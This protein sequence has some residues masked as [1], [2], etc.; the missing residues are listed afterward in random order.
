MKVKYIARWDNYESVGHK[1]VCVIDEEE[2]VPRVGDTF[3]SIGSVNTGVISTVCR[4]MG[5]GVYAF[6]GVTSEEAAVRLVDD[7]ERAVERREP[8]TKS[9]Q[10]ARVVHEALRAY[11]R[12][13]GEPAAGGWDETSQENRD[14]TLASVEHVKNGLPN[15]TPASLHE[16][17]MARKIEQGWRYGPVRNAATKQHPD[18]V[19][20]DQLSPEALMKDEILIALVLTLESGHR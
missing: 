15:V 20:T 13:L 12:T 8:V 7:F 3:G 18:I 6:V 9:I 17:W 16:E 1:T 4:V 19:P 11:K 10:T 5:F 2:Y 14:A